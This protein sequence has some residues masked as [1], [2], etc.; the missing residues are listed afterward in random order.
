MLN[1]YLHS[2][3]GSYIMVPLKE[4][5]LLTNTGTQSSW[6]LF[7]CKYWMQHSAELYQSLKLIFMIPLLHLRPTLNKTRQLRACKWATA[8]FSGVVSIFLNSVSI[9]T[10]I[11]ESLSGECSERCSMKCLQYKKTSSVKVLSPPGKV[12]SFGFWFGW[13]IL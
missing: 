2:I 5:E 7:T 12:G 10:D 9:S 8:I 11:P 6:N 3:H 4:W 1:K 13:L